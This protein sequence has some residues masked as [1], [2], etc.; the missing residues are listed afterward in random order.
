[1]KQSFITNKI[2]GKKLQDLVQEDIKDLGITLVGDIKEVEE[3]IS[4][5][6]QGNFPFIIHIF[7]DTTKKRPSEVQIGPLLKKIRSE[8]YE[9]TLQEM[10][11]QLIALFQG[12]STSYHGRVCGYQRTN[13]PFTRTICR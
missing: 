13:T 12:F 6:K 4:N 8:D 1:L 11:T 10:E 2:N 9:K 5:L 3:A 7:V